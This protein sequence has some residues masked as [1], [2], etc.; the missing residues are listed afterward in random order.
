[1]RREWAI[2]LGFMAVVLV[3]VVFILSRDDNGKGS[4]LSAG[5][6]V[7]TT[8]IRRS[9]TTVRTV[10]PTTASSPSTTD[11][12]AT[13]VTTK[14][15]TTPSGTTPVT[16]ATVPVTVPQTTP[17]T[18]PPTTPPT[19]APP[20]VAFSQSGTY[21]VNI[22]I[23]AGTYH[24]DGGPTGCTWSRLSSVTPAPENNVIQSGTTFGGPATVTV[25]PTDA[26]FYVSD[27]A[28]WYSV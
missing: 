8:T 25:Q 4:Q 27:C 3:G 5:T 14:P 23:P 11:L 26:A 7:P 10:P 28:T 17:P 9:T 2:W 18:E 24:T 1:M 16:E 6:S 20:N 19:T 15:A 12:P 13:P 21:R 22:D